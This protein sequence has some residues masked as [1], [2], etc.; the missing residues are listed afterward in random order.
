MRF[1]DLD[2]SAS[3]GG[4]GVT[5]S[6][7]P[8]AEG[9][10][11]DGAAHLVGDTARPEGRGWEVEADEWTLDETLSITPNGACMA[12]LAGGESRDESEAKRARERSG[13]ERD[14]VRTFALRASGDG[15]LRGTAWGGHRATP[16]R[17]VPREVAR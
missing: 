2:P 15:T 10:S 16:V 9:V 5:L 11:V 1:Y 13:G 3:A 17:C 14:E 4:R 8:C 12:A 7:T 6:H